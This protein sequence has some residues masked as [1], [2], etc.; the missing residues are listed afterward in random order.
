[1]APKP[2]NAGSKRANERRLPAL[3][4]ARRG[5][6]KP[7][8]SGAAGAKSAA[9]N[10]AKP[11]PAILD[12]ED[13]KAARKGRAGTPAKGKAGAK[14]ARAGASG[15][16]VAIM[17]LGALAISL[18]VALPTVPIVLLGMIPTAVAAFVDRSPHKTA[19]IS[20]AG[21]NFAGVAPFIAVLWR[22]PNTLYH[23]I[24]SLSD[25]FSW[26]A[27]YGAAALGWLLFLA[28]PPIATSILSILS[29]QQT[30]SLQAQ[31]AKLR[32]EWGIGMAKKDIGTA[33]K[34]S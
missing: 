7:I 21:L 33:M 28:L 5:P 3:T 13:A 16:M 14:A 27:M 1:M 19:A 20:V 34:E 9:P 8:Q 12:S 24:A 22:G 29:E 15:S 4:V 30:A 6:P 11:N 31:Q 10:R 23:S 17:I 32:E 26:L 18:V 25:V 2:G